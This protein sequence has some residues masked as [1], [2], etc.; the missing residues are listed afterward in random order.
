MFAFG[1]ILNPEFGIA[2]GNYFRLDKL[3]LKDGFSLLAGGYEKH[4]S[5][6]DKQNFSFNYHMI[7]FIAD[8]EGELIAYNK[9]F[10]ISKGMMIGLL[11]ETSH[12][13]K[14]IR[15]KGL[16]YLYVLFQGKKAI[17][18]FKKC[19][20]EQQVVLK[21]ENPDIAGSLFWRI[22]R[23]GNNSTEYTYEICSL[24]LKALF[25]EMA[26]ASKIKEHTST[27]SALTFKECRDYID[28]HYTEIKSINQV[29]EKCCVTPQYLARLFSKQGNMSP[30][31]YLMRVKLNT[32]ANLL[33]T[34]SLSVSQISQRVG[35]DDPFYFST[36][37]R[38][39]YSLSPRKYRGKYM[40]VM[41]KKDT[42]KRREN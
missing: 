33:V 17:E 30:H 5:D 2:E 8:G 21:L 1:R 6:D 7:K 13:F 40:E 35:F 42:K 25:L 23:H 28:G 29:A 16:S 26:A 24:Y 32:A 9:T 34:S 20:F 18:F 19:G 10:K 15:G 14:G 3:P 39:K 41:E 27:L 22:L 11:P 38:K 4:L 12:S 37:F 31:N 36:C